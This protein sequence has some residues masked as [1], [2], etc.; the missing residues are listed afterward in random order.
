V[1]R[2]MQVLEQ[3]TTQGIPPTRGKRRGLLGPMHGPTE[4]LSL[5]G[6]AGHP[7][8][9]QLQSIDIARMTPLEALTTLQRWQEMWRTEQPEKQ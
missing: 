3:L 5:F 9:D 1:E 8:L 7:I 6:A 2:A 4:Q